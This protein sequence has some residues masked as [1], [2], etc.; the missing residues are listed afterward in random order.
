MRPPEAAISWRRWSP[1]SRDWTRRRS[2]TGSAALMAARGCARFKESGELALFSRER[3][4]HLNRFAAHFLVAS[5]QQHQEILT[6]MGLEN[7]CLDPCFSNLRNNM[8]ELVEVLAAVAAG[9]PQQHYGFYRL[10]T[11]L[12]HT[13]FF[14]SLLLVYSFFFFI[15]I[16]RAARQPRAFTSASSWTFS[17]SGSSLHH[18]SQAAVL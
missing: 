12:F 18:P 16:Q 3:I 8:R 7:F 14:S 17:G 2:T 5:P 4:R 11:L 15:G 1:S 6:H 10:E 13:G 9:L